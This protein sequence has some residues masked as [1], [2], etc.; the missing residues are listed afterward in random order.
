[1]HKQHPTHHPRMPTHKKT[2]TRACEQGHQAGSSTL[3]KFDTTTQPHKHVHTHAHTHN[4][5]H[6]FALILF[7]DSWHA[8]SASSVTTYSS[9]PRSGW[10]TMAAA[11]AA[12]ECEFTASM[13]STGIWLSSGTGSSRKN[14][15]HTY[16]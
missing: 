8:T 6:A 1:M 11:A 14:T 5:P 15:W 13:V 7:A 2:H 9:S 12:E 16:T 4:V 3:T 10:R